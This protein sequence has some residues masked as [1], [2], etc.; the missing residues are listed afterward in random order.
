[1]EHATTPKDGR[2]RF[3][4]LQN[5][6]E[7][8]ETRVPSYSVYHLRV[9]PTISETARPAQSSRGTV[10]SG[11]PSRNQPVSS[12]ARLVGEITEP[13]GTYISFSLGTLVSKNRH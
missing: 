1:M 7:W 11:Q 2:E 4:R 6:P 8:T 3:G 9:R 12:Q 13:S 5:M 10:S